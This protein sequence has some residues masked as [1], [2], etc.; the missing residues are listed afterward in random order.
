MPYLLD[1]EKLREVLKPMGVKSRGLYMSKAIQNI[2]DGSTVYPWVKQTSL[3]KGKRKAPKEYSLE[4]EAFWKMYHPM[5]KSAKR[6]AFESWWNADDRQGHLLDIC[7]AT[8]LWQ[9][10]TTAWKEDDGKYF[11][12]AVT[13]LNQRRFEDEDPNEGRGMETYINGEGEMKTRPR[14]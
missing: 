11:P 10:D 14:C 1:P 12:Q 13:W 5:R 6:K 7:L 3:E 9:C 2:L 8:L 4:F